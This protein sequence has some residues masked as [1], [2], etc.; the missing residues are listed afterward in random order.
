MKTSRFLFYLFLLAGL[1]SC[2]KDKPT[3]IETP[4][5]Y[6]EITVQPTYNSSNLFLDSVYV[7][8]EGYKIK[9]TDLKFFG[10]TLK[11]GQNSL[12]QVGFFDFALSGNNFLKVEQD[13]NLFSDLQFF[14]GVDSLINHNDPSTFSNDS[15]LNISNAGT[16]HWGW[17]PGYI[18][19]SVEGKAD[20]LQDGIE[21]YDHNFSFHVGTD[22]Y[23]QTKTFSAINWVKTA[24]NTHTFALQLD[25]FDV[26][27]NAID[28][29][30]LRNEFLAHSSSLQTALTLKFGKNF[31]SALTPY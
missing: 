14:L 29:I 31:K 11:N 28:P 20:T 27:C 3:P 6:V 7:T 13:V 18:F 10:T 17:N 16:M 21:N 25:L 23:L 2:N 1:F 19:I 4:K 24:S 9:F 30:D 5:S 22:D 12:A 8:T 26:I 15:P